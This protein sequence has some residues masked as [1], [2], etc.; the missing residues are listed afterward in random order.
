MVCNHSFYRYFACDWTLNEISDS[1]QL[2]LDWI[3]EHLSTLRNRSNI[4]TGGLGKVLS[5]GY[6]TA[7]C[8]AIAY[9]LVWLLHS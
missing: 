4:G 5:S 6:S 9:N 7:I 1:E 2:F 3:S 8:M